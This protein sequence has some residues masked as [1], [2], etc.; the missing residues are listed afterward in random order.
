MI[1]HLNGCLK[2]RSASRKC[3]SDAPSSLSSLSS[4]DPFSNFFDTSNRPLIGFMTSDKLCEQVL[5]IITEGNLPF[6][7]AENPELVALLR[8]AY[9]DCSIPNRRSIVN[10]LKTNVVEEKDKRKTDFARLG[11]MKVSLALDAWST[12]T[13]IAFLGTSL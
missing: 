13:H 11:S 4:S 10:R 1:K 5:R 7:F 2:Y 12:R 3:I 9:S 8:N 6:S